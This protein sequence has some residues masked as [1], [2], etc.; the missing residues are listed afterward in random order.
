M[1]SKKPPAV[2][3]IEKKT[4]RRRGVAPRIALPETMG[5]EIAR[6]AARPDVI[7]SSAQIA[8]M[9]RQD[10]LAYVEREWAGQVHRK[11]L[12]VVGAQLGLLPSDR[13]IPT[14][15][16]EVRDAV[17]GESFL[18]AAGRQAASAAIAAGDDDDDGS[19]DPEESDDGLTDDERAAWEEGYKW[20]AENGLGAEPKNPHKGRLGIMWDQGRM[21]AIED[22]DA[23]NQPS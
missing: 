7:F 23:E 6:V 22:H 20:L 5:G 12:L 10:V 18:Q 16:P 11:L 17:F 1:A 4:R 2:T 21:A 8:A 19:D 3:G 14:M 13:P 9:I 15:E